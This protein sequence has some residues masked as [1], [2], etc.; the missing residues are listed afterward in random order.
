MRQPPFPARPAQ[1][2]RPGRC[3]RGNSLAAEGV[4]A[5]QGL[6]APHARERRAAVRE[7]VG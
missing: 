4:D 1:P 3:T 6:G 2:T 7:I 5:L